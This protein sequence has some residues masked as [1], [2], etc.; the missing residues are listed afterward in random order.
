ML[1]VKQKKIDGPVH[2]HDDECDVYLGSWKLKLEAQDVK[3]R[4]IREGRKY[5]FYFC[6]G[7]NLIA[8][9]GEDGRYGSGMAFVEDG[10]PLEFAYDLAMDPASPLTDEQRRKLEYVRKSVLRDRLVECTKMLT[11]HAKVHDLLE[12]LDHI[13]D[14]DLASRRARG[15]QV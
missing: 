4:T 10:S 3:G 5:D 6:R 11:W 14:V 2:F 1:I 7:V 13:N 8:R 12:L 15:E 9:H